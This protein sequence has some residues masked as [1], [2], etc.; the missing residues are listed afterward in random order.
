MTGPSRIPGG[1]PSRKEREVRQ[2]LE[3][4]PPAVPKE[5]IARAVTRGATVLRRR[6]ALRRT[7]WLL[8]LAVVVAATVWAMA[9]EPWNVRP[10]DMTPPT[11]G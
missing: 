6:R 8:L 1:T 4:R 2:M 5:L 9:V 3:T 10:V 7:G 11:D